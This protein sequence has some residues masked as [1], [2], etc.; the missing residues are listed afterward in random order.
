[1]PLCPCNQYGTPI[2]IDNL[3]STLI[4]SHNVTFYHLKCCCYDILFFNNLQEKVTLPPR[5]LLFLRGQRK[6]WDF[7]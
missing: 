4:S 3:C 5:F 1:M 2:L 7:Q 6:P